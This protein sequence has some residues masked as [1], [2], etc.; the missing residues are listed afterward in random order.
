MTDVSF[1]QIIL[2]AS[3]ASAIPFEQ[4]DP[5]SLTVIHINDIHAHFEEVNVNTT[6]CRTEDSQDCFGGVARLSQKKKDIMKNDPDA[7]FLNAGDFY[8][9]LKHAKL[10]LKI[11]IIDFTRHC[12]VLQVQV[13]TNDRVWESSQ[14]HCH[15]SRQP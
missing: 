3:L 11:L 15:G 5:F 2:M 1:L 12:L 9:G 6:R 10:P 4:A 8:Q 14:L 7:L 13:Q